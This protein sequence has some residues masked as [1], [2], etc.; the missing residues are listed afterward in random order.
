MAV[1]Q[2]AQA[3]DVSASPDAGTQFDRGRTI[4]VASR[5]HAGYEER[6]YRMGGFLVFPRLRVLATY[7]DN[8]RA[9]PVDR[10][11]DIAFTLEPSVR[12]LSNWSRHQLGLAAT[13]STTRFVKLDS[14]T[15][16]TF[17]V[18]GEGRF[19]AGSDMRL[20]GYVAYRRDVERRS[21][22]G[23]LRDSLRP[24]AY[25][26]VTAGTQLT[27]QGARLRVS[28][29]ASAARIDYADVTLAEGVVLDTRALNRKVYQGGLRADYAVTPN[30]AVLLTGTLGQVDYGSPL[31]AQI[32]D[33]SIRRA[34]LLGG[35]SFEFTDLLRGEVAIG[36]I[37]QRFTSGGAKGFSGL[38]G[39]AEL[40]YQPT[41][42]TSI[43]VDASRTIQDAGNPLAPSFRRTRFGARVD[44]ELLRQLLLTATVDYEK[45]QFQLPTLTERRPHAG[46]SGQY[47]LN[48]HVTVFARYDHLRVTSRPASVGRRFS[49]N[50]VSVGALLKP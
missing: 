15:A 48:R 47:L 45:A 36:Y 43:R 9:A 42:L 10:Q 6:G 4:S 44:H 37:D 30:M 20:F 49:D 16:E 33:R 35:V 41:R 7:E 32:P 40:E 17:N 23:A 34:E 39:R 28:A 12:A 13:G 31:F 2:A 8:V 24:A 21:A 38:G 22:L 1:P 14:E 29:N 3:Q 26:T 11:S 19:D 18:R 25:N 50:I 46:L 27:W 5:I